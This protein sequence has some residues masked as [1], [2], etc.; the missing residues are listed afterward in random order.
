M[1]ASDHDHPSTATKWTLLDT[2]HL[3]VHYH[4]R[5]I[6]RQSE[7][8]ATVPYNNNSFPVNNCIYSSLL[9]TSVKFN[10]LAE[11]TLLTQI[12]MEKIT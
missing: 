10:M 5:Q 4:R 1:A 8:L 9:N 3:Y 6:F 11:Y 7:V 12:Q 2:A